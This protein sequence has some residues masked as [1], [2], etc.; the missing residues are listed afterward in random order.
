MCVIFRVFFNQTSTMNILWIPWLKV[1]YFSWIFF[2]TCETKQRWHHSITIWCHNGIHVHWLLIRCCAKLHT[3]ISYIISHQKNQ[4]TKPN[5]NKTIF[6]TWIFSRHSKISKIY[7]I[8]NKLSEF[9]IDAFL[10]VKDGLFEFL[11]NFQYQ[12][13]F[14]HFLSHIKECI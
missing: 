6:K 8:D 3:I 7:I 13:N 10:S 4:Q 2:P 12:I 9:H 11:M 14:N 1:S 5:Q